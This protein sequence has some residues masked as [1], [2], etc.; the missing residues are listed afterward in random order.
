[1][2]A[3]IVTGCTQVKTYGTFS[4]TFLGSVMKKKTC[5]KACVAS[6]C[7]DQTVYVHILIWA[8]AGHITQWW[9]LGYQCSDCWR[10]LSVSADVPAD[11]NLLW[12]HIFKGRFSSEEA[13]RQITIFPIL[14][15]HLS[16]LTYECLY[17]DLMTWMIRVEK[18]VEISN[19]RK[20]KMK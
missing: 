18:W 8:L 3:A 13:R 9:L 4:F 16:Y 11:L 2:L 14:G 12:S 17:Q 6:K 1:M 15:C 10:L 7:S 20:Y 5:F 19:W